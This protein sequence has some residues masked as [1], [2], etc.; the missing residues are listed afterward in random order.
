MQSKGWVGRLLNIL[1]AP[2]LKLS[3]LTVCPVY[4][5]SPSWLQHSLLETAGGDSEVRGEFD[6]GGLGLIEDWDIG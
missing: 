5:H 1:N 6:A 4:I 2:I 3:C